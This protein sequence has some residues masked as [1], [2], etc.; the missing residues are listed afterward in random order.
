M[1]E[2]TSLTKKE[3]LLLELLKEPETFKVWLKEADSNTVVGIRGDAAHCPIATFLGQKGLNS[4][5]HPDAIVT[6][7]RHEEN[8]PTGWIDTK[9]IGYWVEEFIEDIDNLFLDEVTANAAL[10]VLNNITDTE[11][12]ENMEVDI[13]LK[14]GNSIKV[15]W[16]EV[17]EYIRENRDK[18]EYRKVDVRR[19]ALD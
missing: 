12:D 6:F 9:Q 8:I 3:T 17:D 10:E 15:K 5:V 2:T 16:K 1:T 13:Y 14:N 19:P 11:Y 7:D 18:V 4:K